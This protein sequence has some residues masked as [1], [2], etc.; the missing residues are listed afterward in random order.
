MIVPHR[1]TPRITAD[2]FKKI[3]V[4][5]I[6]HLFKLAEETFKLYP[7]RADRYVRLSWKLKT[8]Y[9]I[10]LPLHLKRKFCKKCLC[11]WKP[12][13]SCRVRLRSER[14]VMTCLKCGHTIRLPHESKRK[15][16]VPTNEELK[17]Y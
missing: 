6:E 10:K 2:K 14:V 15:I 9:N 5:R 1:R 17:G 8:R 12:G 3:A 11:F 7:E 13:T 4:K 16:S